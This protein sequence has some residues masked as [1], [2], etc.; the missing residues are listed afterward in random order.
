MRCSR[1]ATNVGSV[2]ERPRITGLM[3]RRCHLSRIRL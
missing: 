1:P 3:I 2:S